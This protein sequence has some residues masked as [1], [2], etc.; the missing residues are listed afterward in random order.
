M[1]DCIN[2]NYKH[3]ST[4]PININT[5]SGFSDNTNN[6]YLFELYIEGK[7]LGRKYIKKLE[8]KNYSDLIKIEDNILL[9]DIDNYKIKLTILNNNNVVDK[10]I[11]NDI[12]NHNLLNNTYNNGS[13]YIEF[14]KNINGYTLCNSIHFKM[15]SMF[16]SPPN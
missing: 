15:K 14:T 12:I 4:K 11:I 1:T 16:V 5:N 10:Y 7:N 9:S 2:I 13:L 8:N 3:K 6:K